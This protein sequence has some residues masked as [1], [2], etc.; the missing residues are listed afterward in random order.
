MLVVVLFKDGEK[1]NPIP[2]VAHSTSVV[3]VAG[4]V[5]H[6]IPGHTVIFNAQEHFECLVGDTEIRIVELITDV[7]P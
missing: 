4:H 1:A 5:E 6:G 7:E 2:V 3:D